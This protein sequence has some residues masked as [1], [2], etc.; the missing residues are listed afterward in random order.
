MSNFIEWAVPHLDKCPIFADLKRTKEL[1][2]KIM[3]LGQ[4]LF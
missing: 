1:G 2:P 4:N 3:T